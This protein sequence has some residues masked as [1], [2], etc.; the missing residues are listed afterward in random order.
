MLNW[1]V[2]FQMPDTE[3]LFQNTDQIYD[4]IQTAELDFT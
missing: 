4:Q 3:T 1:N 2:F